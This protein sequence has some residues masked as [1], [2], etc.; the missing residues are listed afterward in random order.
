MRGRIAGRAGSASG[1]LRT[2]R[3]SARLENAITTPE[4]LAKRIT[5]SDIGEILLGV[6]AVL[7][8]LLQLGV[9]VFEWPW[10]LAFFPE[11]KPQFWDW[12][13]SD[14]GRRIRRFL[15][16]TAIVAVG[17]YLIRSGMG[18]LRRKG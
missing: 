11:Q 8:G 15:I 14:T 7:F 6:G 12:F 5:M 4:S 13:K 16:G 2:F 1:F 17:V 18:G 9:A 10:Y 3:Q